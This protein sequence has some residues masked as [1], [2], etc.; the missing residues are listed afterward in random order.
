MTIWTHEEQLPLR[1][2]VGEVRLQKLHDSQ[3]E[4]IAMGDRHL[5]SSEQHT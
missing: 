3:E 5:V 2:P 1:T 4:M